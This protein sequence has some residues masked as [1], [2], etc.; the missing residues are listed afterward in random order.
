MLLARTSHALNGGEVLGLLGRLGKLG[1]L[2]DFECQNKLGLLVCLGCLV[3]LDWL[4]VLDQ[5]GLAWLARD[6]E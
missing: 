5:L 3:R 1:W 4:W 6:E 2:G